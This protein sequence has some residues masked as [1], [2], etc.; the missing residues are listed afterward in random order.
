MRQISEVVVAIVISTIGFTIVSVLLNPALD[1]MAGAIY[2]FLTL[3]PLGALIL[4]PLALTI[5]K[6]KQR[7]SVSLLSDGDAVSPHR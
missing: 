2:F 1:G 5:S 7:S 6:R 4:Y 3:I